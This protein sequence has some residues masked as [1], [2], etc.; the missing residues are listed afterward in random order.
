MLGKAGRVRAGVK[1]DFSFTDN[2]PIFFSIV[3]N[4]MGS[5]VRLPGF[6]S[7]SKAVLLSKLL[8]FFQS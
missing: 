1:A 5:E 2:D 6:K 3:T 7:G 8:N 4:S